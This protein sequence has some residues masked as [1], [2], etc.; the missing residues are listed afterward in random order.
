VT[1]QQYSIGG[2]RCL[3]ANQN[4]AIGLA[5]KTRGYM[6]EFFGALGKLFFTKLSYEFNIF[7]IIFSNLCNH[8]VIAQHPSKRQGMNANNDS[9][10]CVYKATVT[11]HAVTRT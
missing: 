9:S 6:N 10:K 1:L 11:I 2:T 4:Q 7:Y 8:H 3:H 5:A